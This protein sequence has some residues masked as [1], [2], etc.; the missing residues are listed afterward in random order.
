MC[1]MMQK[2]IQVEISIDRFSP[3]Q[4]MYH[5]ERKLAKLVPLKLYFQKISLINSL[6]LMTVSNTHT[7][8]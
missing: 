8:V 5:R 6:I 1:H 3:T 7:A 4:Q 2:S